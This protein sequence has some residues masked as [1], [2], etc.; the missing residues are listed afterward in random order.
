MSAWWHHPFH[1]IHPYYPTP[2]SSFPPSWSSCLFHSTLHS[3]GLVQTDS[4]LSPVSA[5]HILGQLTPA[6]I[7][8]EEKKK[9]KTP[10]LVASSSTFSL[11]VV[12]LSLSLNAPLSLLQVSS[13][14]RPL[15]QDHESTMVRGKAPL[16]PPYLPPSGQG[17]LSQPG[18]AKLR[19]REKLTLVF[20][21]SRFHTL[22]WGRQ[23]LVTSLEGDTSTMG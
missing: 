4:C 11:H 15:P 1:H 10:L 9:K 14:A 20:F 19:E 16:D 18:R 12:T 5:H 22:T 6:I 8:H 7:W 2:P 13:V 17:G 21:F 3:V 23:L